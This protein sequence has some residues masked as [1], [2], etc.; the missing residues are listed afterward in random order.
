M[1]LQFNLPN[2]EVWQMGNISAPV[3]GAATP[4]PFF[5]RL[6]S[7]QPDPATKAADPAKVKGADFLQAELRQRVAAGPVGFDFQLTLAPG[8]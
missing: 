8:R 3:F 1:A 7:L 5:G 2:G 4:E 6:A